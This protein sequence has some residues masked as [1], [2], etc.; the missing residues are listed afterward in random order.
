[1]SD[2]P[3]PPPP[4]Q[5]PSGGQP[6]YGGQPPAGGQPP[7]GAAPPPPGSFG[8]NSEEKNGLGVWALIL[9]ILSFV[10]CGP[11]A[12]IIAVVLGKQSMNAEAAGRATNGS[13]GKAGWIIGWVNIVLTVIVLI[14]YVILLV[15]GTITADDLSY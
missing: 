13:L 8:G 14:L 9:G 7:Y 1:M 6:P 3:P 10:C 4:Q 15:T 2:V 11:I 12:A 5:P